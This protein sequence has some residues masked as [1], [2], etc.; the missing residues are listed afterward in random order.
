MN[1]KL[2]IL[3]IEDNEGDVE[4]TK[5]ALRDWTPACNITVVNDGIEALDFLFKQKNFADRPTPHLILLDLNMPR[6]DG[7]RFLET[8]KID[9]KLRTIPV[10][11]LTSSQSPTDIREC[12]E[13]Y[14]SCYVVKPFNSKEFADAVRQVVGFWSTLGQLPNEAA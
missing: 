2:E 7:K 12:Y 1:N 11:M 6:M 10:V 8:I 9:A 13:R 5:R 3:L 14:V 4:M